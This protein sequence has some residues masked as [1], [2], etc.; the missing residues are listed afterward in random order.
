MLSLCFWCS[1]GAGKLGDE[2]GS[3][4]DWE[5]VVKTGKSKPEMV[6]VVTEL[7]REL[8]V[9]KLLKFKSTGW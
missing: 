3:H 4:V 6:A 5:S 9:G 1:D 8:L 2:L 7:E